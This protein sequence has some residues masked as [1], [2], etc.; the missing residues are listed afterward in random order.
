MACWDA[1]TR[2]P[3]APRYRLI[4]SIPKLA[5]RNGGF[6]E[7]PIGLAL[8]QKRKVKMKTEINW[9]C[10]IVSLRYEYKLITVV[11]RLVACSVLYHPALTPDLGWHCTIVAPGSWS[12]DLNSARVPIWGI[13][14]W[15][16]FGV[17]VLQYPII[18]KEHQTFYLLL[19]VYRTQCYLS[20]NNA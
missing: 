12:Q 14:V 9:I 13:L 15:S 7:F 20:S 10:S 18:S 16:S 19:K 17:F 2:R 3:C 4:A 5:L 6:Y 1:A 11:I 8:S